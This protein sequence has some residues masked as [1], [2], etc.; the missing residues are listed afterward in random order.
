MW[1]RRAARRGVWAGS[2]TDPVASITSLAL[3]V[4]EAP[5]SS[6]SVGPTSEPFS[7]KTSTPSAF[8]EPSRLPRT[9]DAK[10][11]A[12]AATASRS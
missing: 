2:R 11:F 3:I 6:T 1:W 7:G 9:R 10:L 12:C 8:S 5:T 4:F